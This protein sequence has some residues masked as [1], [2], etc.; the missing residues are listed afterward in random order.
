MSRRHGQ[1]GG[2]PLAAHFVPV[3][4]KLSNANTEVPI[5]E[6]LVLSI[7]FTG[8]APLLDGHGMKRGVPVSLAGPLY[9]QW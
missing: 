8:K 1:P 2:T 9:D 5:H 7:V 6:I 3:R 4:L